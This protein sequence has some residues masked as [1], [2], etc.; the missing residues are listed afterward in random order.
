MLDIIC[1]NV[2]MMCYIT[3]CQLL[4]VLGLYC[5]T[6]QNGI[7]Y[8]YLNLLIFC[9][10]NAQLKKKKHAYDFHPKGDQP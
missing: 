7:H 4:V 5:I 9:N 8:V 10:L 1:V 2:T 3:S 6:N